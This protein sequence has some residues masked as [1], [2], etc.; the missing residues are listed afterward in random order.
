MPQ[1]KDRYLLS[2]VNNALSVLDVIAAQ[3]P[4][5]LAEL[6]RTTGYDKT[7]LF[8]MTYTLEQNGLLAKDSEG[9]W[10]LGLKL[11]YL[12]G[13]S[14]ARQDANKVARPHLLR[15]SREMG[16]STHLA[17][18]AGTRVV[19][20]GIE[21]PT[22]VLS[23]TGYVGMSA[24]AHSTAMGRAILANLPAQ[25]LK[26][27]EQDFK[28]PAYTERSVQTTEQL[29]TLLADVREHGYAT[30]INDRYRGFGSLAAP[31]FDFS[32]AC[33]AACGIVTTAQDIE[34]RL[35][36][37]AEAVTKLAASISADLGYRA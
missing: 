2:S 7:S 30:D 24:R 21:T 22:S 9:R 5:T 17:R 34:M 37:F 29:D 27:L 28:Y 33:T 26:A 20:T 14:L 15:F 1:E 3:G 31:I 4:L 36:E 6:S 12:G 11:I 10:A 19:T 32:G 23:V 8:R 18:L 25:E 16:V 13:V 35:D